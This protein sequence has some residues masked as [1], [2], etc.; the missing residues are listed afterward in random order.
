M[1][2]L[3]DYD[4]LHPSNQKINI[5]SSIKL[6]P[7][8]L[9][10]FENYDQRLDECLKK[11]NASTKYTLPS[12]Y[13]FVRVDQ[14]EKIMNQSYDITEIFI[15][16]TLIEFNGVLMKLR[17]DDHPNYSIQK[18]LIIIGYLV[19]NWNMFHE[20]HVKQSNV[21]AQIDLLI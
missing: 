13:V 9:E 10:T 16:Q 8:I 2:L 21:D 20:Y 7:I 14:I 17:P 11:Y 6:N 19:W 12:E 18:Q 4:N 3:F 15:D 1:S 5:N